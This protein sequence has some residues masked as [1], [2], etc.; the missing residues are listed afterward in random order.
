[1]RNRNTCPVCCK[2]GMEEGVTQCPQCGSDLECFDLLDKVGKNDRLDINNETNQTAVIIKEIRLLLQNITP[3]AQTLPVN[4]SVN[5]RQWILFALFIA[6]VII[7][8]YHLINHGVTEKVTSINNQL[9]DMRRS[10][11]VQ[12]HERTT[13][14]QQLKHIES[15]LNKSNSS[16][17]NFS[18][19]YLIHTLQS[20]ETLW[21]VAEK[22]Y[23]NADL[24]PVLLEQNPKLNIYK[25]IT[26][27]PLK[28]LKNRDDAEHL[29]KS[30]VFDSDDQ[31]FFLYLVTKDD[32]WESISEKFYT[33]RHNI[34]HLKILNPTVKE[35]H[36]GHRI[37]ILLKD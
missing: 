34:N 2:G 15:E 33:H 16:R 27:L 26:N 11:N 31:L 13:V 30:I 12:E 6:A 21:D 37:V 28:I 9:A 5:W 29:Y 35:L 1:M 7:F 4:H 14:L 32:T 36:S 22:Y 18:N 23:G 20:N 24:Y 10:M 19:E 8:C 3:P 17:F 25:N